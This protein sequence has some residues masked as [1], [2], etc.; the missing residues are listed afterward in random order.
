VAL[1]RGATSVAIDGVPESLVA[2][3]EVS[4]GDSLIIGRN[5]L[6][7]TVTA[8]DETTQSYTVTAIVS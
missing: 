5:T 4:G 3:Y 2:T 7:V 1:A 6:T 8:E